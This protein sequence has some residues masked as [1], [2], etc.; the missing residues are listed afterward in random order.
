M[1]ER[2]EFWHT[3]DVRWGDMDAQGHVN[4]A[5]Y[6]TYFE[7][8]R[9]A[10]FDHVDLRLH[11]HD[12]N[13]GPALVTT[14]ANFR[15]QLRYPATLE[16]GVRLTRIGNR[17]IA[18]EMAALLEGTEDVVADATSVNAWVDYNR[19][20]STDLPESLR[21]VLTPYLRTDE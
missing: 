10:F 19:D 9:I 13:E 17:S 5:R 8:A 18:L 4:N 11:G 20:K 3:L 14:T 15:Q 6:F 12:C 2:Y 1:R 21:E 16:I 7:S